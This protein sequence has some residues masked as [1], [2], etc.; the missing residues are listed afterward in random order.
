MKTIHCGSRK[1]F[2][3]LLAEKSDKIDIN[4]SLFM[5]GFSFA[6]KD[7]SAFYLPNALAFAQKWD[8]LF[9]IKVDT[10]KTRT[11]GRNSFL[12][13]FLDAIAKPEKPVKEVKKE[14]A[15]DNL[16]EEKEAV[17]EAPV[18]PEVKKP[19]PKRKPRAKK[20]QTKAV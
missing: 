13:T 9:D 7:G 1:A 4:K 15:P 10:N 17:T 5:Q 3:Q 2:V 20:A 19:A 16:T 18:E 6:L 8:S 12:V 11:A 14:E